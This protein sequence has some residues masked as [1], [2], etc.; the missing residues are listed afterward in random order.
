M[1][2]AES[3]IIIPFCPSS[4]MEITSWLE[5]FKT[6][7]NLTDIDKLKN[8]GSYLKGTALNLYINSCLKVTTWQQLEEILLENFLQPKICTFLEFTQIQFKYSDDINEYF[9]KKVNV[10]RQL[11]LTTQV[12]LEGLTATMPQNIRTGLVISSPDSLTDWLETASK[13][14]QIQPN[15]ETNQ[16]GEGQGQHFQPQ[17]AYR[18]PRPIQP[19]RY[20]Q[21]SNYPPRHNNTSNYTRPYQSRY[22]FQNNT[23]NYTRPYQSRY[24]SQNNTSNYTRPYQSRY[25]SQNFRPRQPSPYQ[26]RPYY[27]NQHDVRPHTYRNPNFQHGRPHFGPRP[28]LHTNHFQEDRPT[29][30]NTPCRKCQRQGISNAYHWHDEC[31]FL[32]TNDTPASATTFTT[33]PTTTNLPD[34]NI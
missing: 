18:S 9:H 17:N 14:I 31:P 26:Q 33:T 1:A 28:M 12:I 8:I 5:Y 20:S 7:S 25:D 30:P 16:Y 15:R 3:Q 32:L 21:S 2:N 22:D 19:Q 23:S 27:P 11:G 13:L 29:L 6:T 10:G 4:G 34:T 24:D